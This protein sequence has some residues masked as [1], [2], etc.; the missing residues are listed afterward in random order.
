M[1]S[2]LIQQ[3]VQYFNDESAL[4]LVRHGKWWTNG[5]Q[6]LGNLMRIALK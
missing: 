6:C 5:E 3:R 4:L 1:I 2:H